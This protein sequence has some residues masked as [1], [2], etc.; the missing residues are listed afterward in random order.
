[1]PISARELLNSAGLIL[2]ET[3]RWGGPCTLTQRGIYIVSTDADPDARP[4]WSDDLPPLDD[5]RLS[6]LF[7]D[8]PGVSV[9][10]VAATIRSVTDRLWAY[11]L[12]DESVLYVGQTGR[13][14]SERLKEFHRTPLGAPGPH[15][16]GRW[17]NAMAG[18]GELSVHVASADGPF[19]KE[20]EL[21]RQFSSQVSVASRERVGRIEASPCLAPWAN[22]QGGGRRKRHG[23]KGL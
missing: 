20:Q 4:K 21:L 11:W 8:H 22:L 2:H 12:C 6:Q 16:G 18:V 17:V 23:I 19:D 9:D 7:A 15:S 14:V 3:V 10:D 5:Q 1:M 13:K